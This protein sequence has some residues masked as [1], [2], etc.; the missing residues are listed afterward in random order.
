VRDRIADPW[1][2][3]T[4]YPRA[5]EW[6]VR[7]DTYL[8]DGIEPEDV[9]RWVPTASILHSNGDGLDIAV[10]DGRMVGVRGRADSRINQGRLGPKDLFGWQ[11]NASSDRLTRPL[12][13]RDG[14]LVETDWDTAMDALVSHS[15]QLLAEQG[16]NAFGIYTSGQLFLEEYYT[17]GVIGARGWAATT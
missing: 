15:K 5:G 14:E 3:R 8:Q 9:E 10:K 17:L 11:A 1:G 7:V 4:P 16:P 13:R 12:V 6:P 2:S